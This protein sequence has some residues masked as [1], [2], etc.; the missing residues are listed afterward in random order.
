MQFRTIAGKGAAAALTLVINQGDVIGKGTFGGGP[1]RIEFPA[2]AS[3]CQCYFAH[4]RHRIGMS[5]KALIAGQH[6]CMLR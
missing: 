1:D 4:A 6:M 2:L 5:I 3:M